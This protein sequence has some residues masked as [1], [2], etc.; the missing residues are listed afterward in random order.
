MK[1][2]LIVDDE[3]SV[4]EILSRLLKAAQ[5]EVLL[6]RDGIEGLKK[7]KK[8]LPDLVVSDVVMPELDGI[9]LCAAV[10]NDPTTGH[11]PF[12]FITTQAKIGEIEEAMKHSPD[13]YITKPFELPRIM[14]KVHALLKNSH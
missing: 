8:S 14:Q 13:G 6:A 12:L 4:R 3:D 7:A 9:S 10:K 11:I 1:K 5:F 2:I